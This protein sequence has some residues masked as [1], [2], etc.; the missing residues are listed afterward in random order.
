MWVETDSGPVLGLHL[1]MAGRIAV[2]EDAGPWDRLRIE[3]DDGGA[4][5]LRDKRRLSRAVLEPAIARLGPDAAEVGRAEFAA[6][7]GR[8]R[9]PVKARIMNQ[10]AIAGIGNLLADEAL[11]R[12]RI[13]P[14]RPAET[15][16]ANDLDRL[17]RELRAAIR[18]ATTKGGV[19]TGRMIDARRAGGLCP[20]CG[21]E[22]R[23]AVVGG[24]TT[25]FCPR[26]QV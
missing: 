13:D 24:R 6:R 19:H 12:A 4:L 17:R 10:A 15:L 1:G 5:A 18:S 26:E 16:S 8:S 3:F 20:R 22:M 7:V 23:R 21:T 25:W 2:D 11:W 14:R 9:A